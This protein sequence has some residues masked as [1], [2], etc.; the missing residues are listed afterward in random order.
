MVKKEKEII[1]SWTH[2]EGE[3][4]YIKTGTLKL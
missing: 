4:T 3:K 2:V 1:F